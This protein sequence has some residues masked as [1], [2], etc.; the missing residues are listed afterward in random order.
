MNTQR[1]AAVFLA[2]IAVQALGASILQSCPRKLDRCSDGSE[3]AAAQRLTV[4]IYKDFLVVMEGQIGDDQNGRELRHQNF[5]IDTGTAPSIVNETVVQRLGLQTSAASLTAVGRTFVTRSTV[6]PRLLLGPIRT[7][8]LPVQVKS[9]AQLERDL[10]IPVAGI[11]GMDVLSQSDFRLDYEKRE[12]DFGVPKDEG[13]PV[14]FD[15]HNGIAIADVTLEGRKV[16]M[17]VDT[18]SDQVS[19]LGGNLA[20][21]LEFSLRAAAQS[22]STVAENGMRVQEFAAHDIELAGQHFRREKAYLLANGSDPAFDGLLGVRALGFRGISF[23][24]SQSVLYLEK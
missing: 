13:I 22:G 3:P 2:T 17:L 12:I 20:G 5:V 4:R 8:S 11:I 23:N 16:R 15:A 7:K 9:L 14:A 1:A 18:G 24:Q 10:A 21:P 6:I 19:L